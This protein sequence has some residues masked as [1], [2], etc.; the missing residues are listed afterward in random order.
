[1]TNSKLKTQNSKFPLWLALLIGLMAITVAYQRPAQLDIGGD[2]DAPHLRRF[3]DR[4]ETGQTTFRWSTDYSTIRFRGVGMPIAPAT[5]KLQAGS[6][7][8][9]EARPV[10]VAVSV[11]GH[12]A[13]W[14]ALNSESALYT[15][16]VQPE[17]V[18]LSGD[19]R[20][21]FL[22]PTFRPPGDKR[23]LGFL[24]DSARVEMPFAATLPPVSQLFW[25]VVC[26]LLLYWMLQSVRVSTIGASLLVMLFLLGCASI[27]AVQRL[28]LTIF[29]TRLAVTLLLAL[30]VG[31][32]AEWLVRRVA[33]SAGWVSTRALP[34]WA[35]LG[36]RGLIMAA[37]ALKVGGLLHPNSFIIDAEFH[38]RYIGF[39]A[40]GKP[41]EQYFGESLAL[42]VMPE[43]EWGQARTFIPYSPFFYVV[44]A[45]FAWL[46]ISTT[47]SV[48]T[49][50]ATL[51]ALKIA[52]V[53]L[54]G[55]G[56]GG[57][58]LA[59]R[60][61]A[62]VALG[63]ATFYSL[64]PATFLL[65][66]WGNWPTQLSLWLVT[67]W[68]AVVTLYW[69]RLTRPIVWGVSTA[70]LTLTMLSYTVTAVYMGL[71]VGMV[72]VFGWLFARDERRRWAA[73][74]LSLVSSTG[75]ALLIYYG[76]YI[77]R[78]LGDTLPTFGQAIE[79][80][81]S[82]TTLRPTIWGFL[83]SHLARAMQSYYLA[84][85]YAIG[86]AGTL[87]VFR[88]QAR[89]AQVGRGM[90]R[91]AP[92]QWQRV[93]LGA[94]LLTFPLFTLADFWV[95][96]ALKEFWF[97][98]PAVSVVAALWLLALKDR[99]SRI[100]DLFLWLLALILLWQCLSLWV[101]RLFFH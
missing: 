96:Q 33:R 62:R 84:L 35:W 26:A 101:F 4:E 7:R 47:I 61:S 86:I 87:W 12:S 39:M 34:E 28:M 57:R 99:C 67:L 31:F 82:L 85:I 92:T 76:Q 98:L 44:A 55:L 21:D 59:R 8:D 66:Q 37:V 17:W 70:L 80:Q 97:A 73:L 11:N 6:G 5:V 83:T 63:A 14:L 94:W 89:G 64:I 10:E 77:G 75:L 42:S 56:L 38:L 18:D 15:I 49:V 68:V 25:L 51:D 1:M 60:H 53:F 36:V 93:W 45:P 50:M 32:V 72:I 30:L 69:Q 29:T 95:D 3:H 2:F 90:A 65:Q 54:I 27:L 74:L 24:V 9:S 100:Y 19:V 91:H 58:F 48:P 23:D 40:E 79:T 43:N 52:L 41:W 16:D 13:G 22:S 46:P 81:G 88:T 78:I 71:F 20:V